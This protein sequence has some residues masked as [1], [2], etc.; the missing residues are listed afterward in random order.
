MTQESQIPFEELLR[1]ATGEVRRRRIA[2][3]PSEQLLQAGY[4]FSA[5][6]RRV[7]AGLRQLRRKRGRQILPR[8]IS[9]RT[10]KRIALV[11]ALLAALLL[12]TLTASAEVRSYVREVLVHWG[13]RNMDLQYETDGYPLPELPAGYGSHYIPEG[14]VYIEE[15]SYEFPE[16]FQKYYKNAEGCSILIEANTANNMA[17]ISID[18]EHI[19]YQSIDFGE[20]DA[21]LGT[22]ENG[23]GYTMIWYANG[24]E[25]F[26]YVSADIEQ[27]EVFRIAENIY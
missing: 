10:A 22:F 18:T 24:I 26:L 9:L 7:A 27:A 3:L 6:D 19:T 12:G 14:F 2:R 16:A 15:S 4:D 23:G 21:F 8:R 11:A 20:S 17:G 1:R 5:L 13:E 25:H